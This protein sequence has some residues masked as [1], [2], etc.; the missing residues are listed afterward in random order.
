MKTEKVQLKSALRRCLKY[1]Q[2]YSVKECP[3]LKISSWWNYWL[4][5]VDLTKWMLNI[6]ELITVCKAYFVFFLM[7]LYDIFHIPL[8]P[9]LN[10]GSME[11]I[12]YFFFFHSATTLV[13]QG[14]LSVED[15]WSLSLRHTTLSRNI[16]TYRMH[17][18]SRCS[19]V[20]TTPGVTVG[21]IPKCQWWLH[22]LVCTICY[23]VGL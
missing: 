22:G 7:Y 12:T 4:Y 13:G 2:L 1:T 14:L 11:Y 8:S 20:C 21:Q 23:H 10:S 3:M 5:R 16:H 15:S 9:W 17:I 6:K 18:Y 19:V